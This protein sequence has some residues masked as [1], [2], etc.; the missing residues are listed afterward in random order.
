MARKTRCA[1]NQLDLFS[2]HQPVGPVHFS[3]IIRDRALKCLNRATRLYGI[4]IPEPEI[5]FSLRG[6]AAGQ[7]QFRISSKPKKII[8]CRL[9]FNLPIALENQADFLATVV[10]HEVA[11]LVVVAKWGKGKIKPHGLEWQKVMKQCFGLQPD[12]CHSYDVSKH[13]R[14]MPRP[15]IYS[16]GCQEFALTAQMHKRILEGQER[17]CRE[18][19]GGLVFIR[20][21]E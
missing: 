12:R 7:A 17:R 3:G 4:I 16:C 6:L 15:Y 8:K 5:D 13:V 10:P 2:W 14:R 1:E 19:K 20:K 18:C 9:R 21:C 11:H